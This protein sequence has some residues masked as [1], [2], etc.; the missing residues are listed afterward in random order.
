[1]AALSVQ[2]PYPVF[3]DRDGVPLDNGNIYIGVVN[4]DPV[5]NPLQVYYDEALT[6]TAAQP[7]KTSNGYVYR[8]GTPTQLYVNAVNFSI[9]A[10]NAN[11]TLVYSFPDGTGLGVGAVSI[12]LTPSGYTTATNVQ[13]AFN[14]LGSTAGSSKVGFI[15]SAAGAVS[16]ATQA[17]LRDSVSVKDFYDP[18]SAHPW[19]D[20]FEAAAN[21]FGLD[22]AGQVIVPAGQYQMERTVTTPGFI[23]WIGNGAELYANVNSQRFFTGNPVYYTCFEGFTFFGNGRTGVQAFHL[24]NW[25]L[26]SSITN[27]KAEDVEYFAFLDEGCFGSLIAN[28]ATVRVPFPIRLAQNNAGFQ[29]L[30]CQLDNGATVL[31]LG[32]G[33]G[34]E[35]ALGGI[36]PSVGVKIAGGYIQGFDNGVLDAG[37]GTTIDTVYFET[38]VEAD[39]FASNT[40]FSEYRSCNHPGTALSSVAY[41]L[42]SCTTVTIFNPIV[43]SGGRSAVFDVN[44]SN[45]D[46]ITYLP[47][48]TV[49]Y[50]FPTGD[51]TYLGRIQAEQR[52]AGTPTVIGS[53]SA[54]TATYTTRILNWR[55]TAY[56]AHV[57]IA[58][59]WTGHTG[60]GNLVLTGIPNDIAPIVFDPRRIGQVVA[61]GFA[62]AAGQI[63]VYFNGTGSQLSFNHV[64]TLGVESLIAVPS[65]GALTIVMDYD[66]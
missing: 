6:I 38:N 25:R 21:S 54:G 43:P 23:E 34:I 4:L 66:R 19:A 9:T 13:A 3:Y 33:I 35:I 55:K 26:A 62:I 63:Y 32:V 44:S 57:E 51:M 36:A 47:P 40:L 56:G 48:N 27:C 15:A 16:R 59:S 60:T 31:G 41:K 29:I 46:C 10:K 52:G 7:L 20:A 2:V 53:G 24:Q 42:R 12:A 18:T 14:D 64:S 45:T 37:I 8:N 39:I 49:S 28:C 11:N 65:S 1:M 61:I 30:S 5:T 50:N 17:K 58:I 22:V